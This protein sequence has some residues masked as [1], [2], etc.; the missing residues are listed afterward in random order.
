[1]VIQA[2][3]THL[4]KPNNQSYFLTLVFPFAQRIYEEDLSKD[5]ASEEQDNATEP[6]K[7]LQCFL[8][9]DFYSLYYLNTTER[10]S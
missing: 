9:I 7:V 5:E 8:N 4:I 2:L 6:E 1:M 10:Q 3:S